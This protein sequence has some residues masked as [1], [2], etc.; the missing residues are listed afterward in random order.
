MGITKSQF[1]DLVSKYDYLI[2]PEQ[3]LYEFMHRDKYT[4]NADALIK[5][6]KEQLASESLAN[7][8]N[9]NNF[10]LGIAALAQKITPQT[11]GEFLAETKAPRYTIIKIYKNSYLQTPF[12]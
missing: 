11:R 12:L 8:Y 9:A 10:F 1:F 5:Y 3:V 6:I 2:S 7:V 4:E